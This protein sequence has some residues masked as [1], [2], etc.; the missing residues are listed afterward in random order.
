VKIPLASGLRTVDRFEKMRNASE[1]PS[2]AR[3]T[4]SAVLNMDTSFNLS[5]SRTDD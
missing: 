4:V 1:P 3:A 5:E 2:H